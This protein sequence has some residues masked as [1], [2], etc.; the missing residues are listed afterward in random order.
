MIQSGSMNI[1]FTKHARERM[2]ERGITEDRVEQAIKVPDKIGRSVLNHAR[3]LIKK[4]YFN[5]TLAKKHLLMIIY[6]E[7]GNEVYVITLVDTS[8]IEKYL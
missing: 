1:R 5:E 8:K 4:V 6:E 2:A 7:K 3:F